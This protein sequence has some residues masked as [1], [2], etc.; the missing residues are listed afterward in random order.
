[1]KTCS[2]ETIETRRI[3]RDE[4]EGERRLRE[5]GGGRRTTPVVG[6]K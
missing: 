5:N 3:M 4:E 2:P 6:S 1:M